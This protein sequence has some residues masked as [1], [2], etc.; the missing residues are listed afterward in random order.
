[1]P[2]A[3]FLGKQ[4]SA[5][6]PF[7]S[8]IAVITATIDNSHFSSEAMLAVFGACTVNYHVLSAIHACSI[9]SRHTAVLSAD[10]MT[11]YMCFIAVYAV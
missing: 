7:G 10:M 9:A 11:R 1:V 8:V 6:V 3:N 4:S 5:A 2:Y